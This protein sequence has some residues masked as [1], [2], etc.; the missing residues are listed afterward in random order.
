MILGYFQETE[1]ETM[2]NQ[3]LEQ[4]LSETVMVRSLIEKNPC[5]LINAKNCRILCGSFLLIEI[6]LIFGAGE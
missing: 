2:R 1:L 5:I 3:L 4:R 6:R